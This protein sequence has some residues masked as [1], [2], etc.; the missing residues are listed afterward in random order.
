MTTLLYAMLE[1]DFFQVQCWLNIH[2]NSNV[3]P[4]TPLR[5]H[6]IIPRQ[7]DTSGSSLKHRH[8]FVVFVKQANA[9]SRFQIFACIFRLPTYSIWLIDEMGHYLTVCAS[10]DHHLMVVKL[11]FL[12]H[13][14][15]SFMR[16]PSAW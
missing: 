14:D 12:C 13:I 3:L 2:S 9:N 5:F 16:P 15:D 4:A 11:L 6:H 8:M 7:C 1:N 10:N